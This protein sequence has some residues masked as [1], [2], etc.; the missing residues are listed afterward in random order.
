MK[1]SNQTNQAHLAGVVEYTDYITAEGSPHQQQH[2][3]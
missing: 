3:S 1:K 2:M